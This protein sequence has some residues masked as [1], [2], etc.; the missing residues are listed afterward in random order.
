MPKTKPTKVSPSK[1]PAQGSAWKVARGLLHLVGV[2]VFVGGLVYVVNITRQYDER[3]ASAPTPALRVALVNKPVWM[4]DFLARE[5]AATVPKASSSVFDHDLL[6]QAVAKLRSNPW[7]STVHQVRRV[8]G[9]QPG[10]TL[11]VDCDFRAPVALVKWGLNYWMVDNEGFLLPEQFT[12]DH[13]DQVTV[14][15][16]GRTSL[17]VIQGVHQPPPESGRKWAGTD[18]AAGLDLVKL[19]Y[20]KLYLDEITA[21]DVANFGGRVKRSDPQLVLD[22]RYGTQIWWGRPLN[23]RDFFVEISPSRKL[24][25]LRALVQKQ[26]RVDANQTYVDVRYDNLL[27]PSTQPA[28][29]R[30][31]DDPSK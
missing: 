6:V 26:G 9:E 11:E 28:E 13:L 3:E 4:S 10:D 12:A 20:N 15:R 21:V 22:T 29:A 19:F 18:L 31:L 5:I 17:R 23:T 1:K 24:E 2:F 7:V 14:G 25:I 30:T 16:D 8:Y 27:I